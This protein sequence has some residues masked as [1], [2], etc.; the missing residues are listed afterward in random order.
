MQVHPSLAALRSDRASQ[1]RAQLRLTDAYELWRAGDMAQAVEEDLAAYEAG[2]ALS[3]LPRLSAL[4]SQPEKVQAWSGDLIRAM[5]EGLHDEPLGE[6]PLPSQKSDN[7]AA[8]RVLSHGAATLS[9]CVYTPA[10]L[11]HEPKS[12]MFADCDAHELV[13]GGSARGCLHR[14]RDVANGVSITTTRHHWRRADVMALDQWTTRHLIPDNGPLLTLRLARTPAAPA[15]TR[16]IDLSTGTV[17]KSASA[18]KQ[19]SRDLMALAV[20][21]A[22]EHRPALGTM[23]RLAINTRADPDLRWE[24]VRQSLALDAARGFALL[25]ALANDPTDPLCA[26]AESLRAQLL[27]AHPQ[28]REAA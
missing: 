26:A 1:R 23:E 4:L 28:L 6:V 5:I 9:L 24:A 19:A 18:D 12:A 20:L 7:Y 25:S 17:L 14:L 10:R 27:A 3:D 13:L 21:G 2:G 16:M 8:T 15:P 22:L 11:E